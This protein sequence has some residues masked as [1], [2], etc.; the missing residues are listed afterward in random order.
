MSCCGSITLQQPHP[1][2]CLTFNPKSTEIVSCIV[3]LPS[4]VGGYSSAK[5]YYLHIRWPAK[6]RGSMVFWSTDNHLP[7]NLMSWTTQHMI[8]YSPLWEQSKECK[9][10]NYQRWM[11]HYEKKRNYT[12]SIMFLNSHYRSGQFISLEWNKK[13][14]TCKYFHVTTII[15]IVNAMLKFHWCWMR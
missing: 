2:H 1:L 12:Y 14:K 9:N 3:T 8:W 11:F 15:T 6:D 7:D 4:L 10:I 5:T 13:A